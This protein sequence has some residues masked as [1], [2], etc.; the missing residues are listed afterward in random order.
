MS[1][2]HILYILSIYFYLI[3]YSSISIVTY[4]LADFKGS[5]VVFVGSSVL[6]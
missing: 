2:G 4:V 6:K 5:V 3:L 1:G